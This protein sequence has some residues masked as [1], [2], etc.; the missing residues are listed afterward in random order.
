M[1]WESVCF[2][3]PWILNCTWQERRSRSYRKMNRDPVNSCLVRMLWD[4]ACG[5]LMGTLGL[6]TQKRCQVATKSVCAYCILLVPEAA[7]EAKGCCQKWHL[8]SCQHNHK[9]EMQL[10][11]GCKWGIMLC[12]SLCNGA[13]NN[14][15]L[16]LFLTTGV[17]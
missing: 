13:Q 11:T 1:F 17:P 6:D 7:Q 15:L 3:C 5:L 16:R 9:H 4:A 12:W 14:P 2:L 10:S 8:F